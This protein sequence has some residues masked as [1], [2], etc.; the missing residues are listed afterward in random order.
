MSF[1]VNTTNLGPQGHEFQCT[2][3]AQIFV[4]HPPDA[5]EKSGDD[6]ISTLSGDSVILRMLAEEEDVDQDRALTSTDRYQPNEELESTSTNVYS[7]A[8]DRAPTLRGVQVVVPEDI[9]RQ[10]IRNEVPPSTHLAGTQALA[11]DL[12]L[13]SEPS[14][15]GQHPV[16]ERLAARMSSPTVGSPTP[17][18]GVGVHVGDEVP[19]RHGSVPAEVDETPL[20]DTERIPLPDAKAISR[21][22]KPDARQETIPGE[23]SLVFSALANVTDGRKT[24][25]SDNVTSLGS[26]DVEIV[27]FDQRGMAANVIPENSPP[28]PVVPN[29]YEGGI[30]IED[31]LP[32]LNAVTLETMFEAP[33]VSAAFYGPSLDIPADASSVSDFLDP[34]EEPSQDP[35]YEE[36]LEADFLSKSSSNQKP[37]AP[38]E[39]MNITPDPGSSVGLSR[40]LLPH[41]RKRD[42]WPTLMGL[43]LGAL[44]AVPCVQGG[45]VYPSI[46]HHIPD[47]LTDVLADN[48]RALTYVTSHGTVVVVQG[49]AVHVGYKPY[50]NVEVKVLVMSGLQELQRRSA[51]VGAQLKPQDIELL[52]AVDQPSVS[53]TSDGQYLVGARKPF[54]VVLPSPPPDAASYR[55][56]VEFTGKPLH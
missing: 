1:R 7:R 49:E 44:L 39:L 25:N 42:R 30:L 37:L 52:R 47:A 4:A 9:S 17:E 26:D 5:E 36:A 15:L 21:A 54:M 11:N 13:E 27:I 40:D 38:C 24:P 23:V 53:S 48:V 34:G 12:L 28:D 16:V 31:P 43:L 45:W 19:Q 6:V 46:A 2:H 10:T 33:A 22:R 29:S 41:E 50:Q 56:R 55:Y 8:Q 3:C 14:L 18:D 20:P 51:P 32:R 35:D